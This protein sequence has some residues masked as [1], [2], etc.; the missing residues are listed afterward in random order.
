[1]HARDQPKRRGGERDD[2]VEPGRAAND[3][4]AHVLALQRASGN[5]AVANMV[6][7]ARKGPKER[8]ASTDAPWAAKSKPASTS[9][10]SA[11]PAR[12]RPANKGLT[13]QQMSWDAPALIGRAGDA[14][15]QKDYEYAA[16][17][18]ERA[19]ELS[20]RRDLAFR[21][22]RTYKDLGEAEQA[23]YWIKVSQGVITPEKP[24]TPGEPPVAHQQF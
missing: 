14:A 9:S 24:G 5:G 12:K 6:Q 1:V 13:S 20:P 11:R 10:A 22:S 21:I 8:P 2:A 16:A 7:L 18:L 19:Y 15:A 3:P 17:L 23:D 4:V